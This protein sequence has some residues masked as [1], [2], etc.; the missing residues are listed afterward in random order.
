MAGKMRL[1]DR[2]PTSPK[3][4]MCRLHIK[5]LRHLGREE[6]ALFGE[7]WRLRAITVVGVSP[8]A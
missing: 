6:V 3:K 5:G 4:L 7:P 8:E 1:S 2:H